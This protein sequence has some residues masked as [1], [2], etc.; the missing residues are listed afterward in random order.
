MSRRW[1]RQEHCCFTAVLDHPSSHWGQGTRRGK[2]CGRP[3]PDVLG[4]DVVPL[5]FGTVLGRSRSG[6][7]EYGPWTIP[8]AV[9][10]PVEI[11]RRPWVAYAQLV[12][13]VRLDSLRRA[14]KFRASEA[15]P[16]E[17]LKYPKK[18]RRLELLRTYRAIN[19][20]STDLRLWPLGM[21]RHWVDGV[22]TLKYLVS[23]VCLV[24]LR[25]I[26]AQLKRRLQ[27]MKTSESAT[28]KLLL[29]GLG[30]GAGITL[31]GCS[32]N[33]APGVDITQV[34]WVVA[35]GI[36][37]YAG[38]KAS[39]L[40][41]TGARQMELIGET[42]VAQVI[43]VQEVTGRA[44][45][46]SSQLV[47]RATGVCVACL[48]VFY[49]IHLTHLMWKM[50][51]RKTG[52]EPEANVEGA[53][54]MGAPDAKWL[55]WLNNAEDI[56]ALMS[57]PRR[58]PTTFKRD[59]GALTLQV[60]FTGFRGEPGKPPMFADFEVPSATREGRYDVC[61]RTDC[62]DITALQAG[63]TCPN[64]AIN[65]GKTGGM[66]CKHGIA[67]IFAIR[68]GR[69]QKAF[70][71]EHGDPKGSR[72]AQLM[73]QAEQ[74]PKG[75]AAAIED[76]KP[77]ADARAQV[78]TQGAAALA[79]AK[80]ATGVAQ[81]SAG[82]EQALRSGL[83]GSCF[84]GFRKRIS[85]DSRPADS[86]P[87]AASERGRGSR[88]R[89]PAPEASELEPVEEE[90][91]SERGLR[92]A[93]RRYWHSAGETPEFSR[94]SASLGERWKV[95]EI[96]L[97]NEVAELRERIEMLKSAHE[98]ERKVVAEKLLA[99]ERMVRT[100]K[101]RSDKWKHQAEENN[102]IQIS[103]LAGDDVHKEFVKICREEPVAEVWISCYSFDR[104]E[105]CEGL[106]HILEKG[107]RVVILADKDQFCHHTKEMMSALYALQAK[108]AQIRLGEGSSLKDAY[109]SQGREFGGGL[110]GKQH[111]KTVLIKFHVD[112]DALPGEEYTC[113]IGSANW[114]VATGANNEANV[115][116][117][118]PSGLF[119]R[120]WL[121]SFD[122]WWDRGVE[123]KDAERATSL[124]RQAERAR[125][126]VEGDGEDDERPPFRRSGSRNY[127]P[128]GRHAGRT[129]Y[130]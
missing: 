34:A 32:G 120:D 97:E 53:A 87:L 96:Q 119:V 19:I 15:C 117:E 78:A 95:R 112:S 40:I 13:D 17:L 57:A 88:K 39:D 29:C 59:V 116:I 80:A 61:L 125:R 67:A 3:R 58:N 71:F 91:R 35:V 63:C 123:P 105:T 54:R 84:E 81:R 94:S 26:R 77:P 121:K 8:G 27:A 46:N 37:G 99:T 45:S 36:L 28:L 55:E 50:L 92:S 69:F 70:C 12:L 107:A 24:R 79:R 104:P 20:L 109:R 38:K 49:L 2:Y 31:Q 98:A 25:E 102:R 110:V 41:D 101:E 66:V 5:A 68:S 65:G 89:E 21:E 23:S 11:V 130:Q 9:V 22:E 52:K 118:C 56:D 74:P 113:L 18:K 111:C 90:T 16:A 51:M 115:K 14:R 10:H 127:Q 43:E 124:R 85:R 76:V 103:Y 62:P 126:I 73:D 72:V 47:I 106:G 48:V 1:S 33:G 86:E 83:A 30:V 122:A 75:P 100:A 7:N 108:G 44:I 93:D 60:K 129:S 42:A 6:E 82:S 4:Q 114:S 128:R 64:Y